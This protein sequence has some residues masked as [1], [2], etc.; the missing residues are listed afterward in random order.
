MRSRSVLGLT[1]PFSAALVLTLVLVSACAASSTDKVPITTKSDEARNE[2]VQGRNLNEKL[3]AQDALQHLDRAL[4]LDSGFATAELA[5]AN[6]SNTAKDFLAHLNKAVALAPN[7]SEGERYLILAAEAA[8]N[9][10]VKQQKEYLDKVVA[11]YPRDER[12]HFALG[13]YYFGQQEF[14]EAVAQYK[15]ATEIAP[16][17]SPAY[18][19]LGYALRSQEDYA[20]AEQAFQKYI[21]LIP[22]DPNPYDSYAELL[23]K[24]GRFDESIAQYRKALAVNNQ[25]FP[26][27]IGIATDLMYLGKAKESQAALEEAVT[28]SRNDGEKRQAL[29][30]LA[31]LG[32]DTGNLPMALK[33][34]DREYAVAEKKNDLPAMAADLQAKG[35]IL[36]N[37]AK[38]DDAR[39]A[40]EQSQ[41]LV[42]RSDVSAQ[43]KSNAESLL[44]FNLAR[45]AAGKGDFAAASREADAFQKAAEATG[46]PLQVKQAHSLRGTIA[47]A[48]KQYDTATTELLQANQ[49][50]PQDLY[51]LSLAYEGKGDAKS[52]AQYRAKAAGFNSLPAL[53]YAFVRQKAQA[54]TTAKNG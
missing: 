23:M 27:R 45:V 10:D 19:L 13:G 33:S 44:H 1:V 49:Q 38:Y 46:N 9:G 11:A 40:F 28:V 21:A 42:A 32:S 24:M 18:N 35:N 4:S 50:N 3:Q 37:F 2:Y 51:R 41:K 48:Q 39:L 54:T 6:A 30:C 47:L 7:V 17:Y 52:A 36:L 16:D 43:V 53:P 20:G 12:V 14:P 31:V 29:F 8:N 25:F 5:R 34:M 15:E 22:N 26:S